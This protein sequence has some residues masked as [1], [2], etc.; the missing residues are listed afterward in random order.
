MLIYFSKSISLNKLQISCFPNMTVLNQRLYYR[1][2]RIFFQRSQKK[3][4]CYV[5]VFSRHLNLVSLW[6][7]NI[8]L[9]VSLLLISYFFG[10]SAKLLRY[11]KSPS[12]K[13]IQVSRTDYQ[14]T[15]ITV[16]LPTIKI[17]SILSI[18]AISSGY[19]ICTILG[20]LF[21]R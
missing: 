1:V 18:A 10:G 13:I 20:I 21:F 15:D 4:G 5:S 16:V 7:N 11:T 2:G 14:V 9:Y 17:A 6:L 8:L 19:C 12:N 3:N